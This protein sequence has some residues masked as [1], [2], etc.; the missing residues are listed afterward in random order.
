MGNRS[1]VP[2]LLRELPGRDSYDT[3]ASTLCFH[4]ET[5]RNIW[6]FSLQKDLVKVEPLHEISLLSLLSGARNNTEHL[7]TGGIQLGRSEPTLAL[8]KTPTCSLS[9]RQR[10][11]P[12]RS[13]GYLQLRMRFTMK[14]S[15]A[16]TGPLSHRL[17]KTE[18]RVAIA[19]CSL[20]NGSLCGDFVC[21]DTGFGTCNGCY[22]FVYCG[23]D[24]LLGIWRW[25]GRDFT[26]VLGMERQ[27]RRGN[28]LLHAWLPADLN[29]P[30]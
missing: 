14:G 13:I 17:P 12:K 3:S 5:K 21:I 26:P 16:E 24:L 1:L 29:I 25:D 10:A 4:P 30:N 2:T 18:A 20:L 6:H 22:D 15:L 23:E 7:S 11:G 28:F 8:Q 19:N 9:A 27:R